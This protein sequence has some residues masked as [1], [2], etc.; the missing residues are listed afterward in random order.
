MKRNQDKKLLEIS[1]IFFEEIY[2]LDALVRRI[3]PYFGCGIRLLQENQCGMRFLYCHVIVENDP[4]ILK[5]NKKI[6][7]L[8]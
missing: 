4:D 2:S 7:F 3:R 1:R 8:Y 5:H 6:C